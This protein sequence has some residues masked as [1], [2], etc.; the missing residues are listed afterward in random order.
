MDNEL[1]S[2]LK[3]AVVDE[4]KPLFPN[5]FHEGLRK[6]TI[7]MVRLL[8]ETEHDIDIVSRV[9]VAMYWCSHVLV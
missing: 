6:I 2:M 4:L 7:N 8:S 1:E 9:G 5:V 3:E